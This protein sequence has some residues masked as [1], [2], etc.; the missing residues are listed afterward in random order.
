LRTRRGYN[1]NALCNYFN[2]NLK[3]IGSL[4]GREAAGLTSRPAYHYSMGTLLHLSLGQFGK[5]LQIDF[6]T[7]ERCQ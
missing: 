7:S 4:I 2:G 1:G 3:K 5:L 6:A